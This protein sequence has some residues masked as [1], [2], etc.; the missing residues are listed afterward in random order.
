M[1]F[2][3]GAV[4]GMATRL[5]PAG[6]TPYEAFCLGQAAYIKEGKRDP[7]VPPAE[8]SRQAATAAIS[9]ALVT[10]GQFPM[11]VEAH[12]QR[13]RLWEH[14]FGFGSWHEPINPEE[15]YSPMELL[16]Q[17]YSVASSS[18]SNGPAK[19]YGAPAV[20]TEVSVERTFRIVVGSSQDGEFIDQMSEALQKVEIAL[21]REV[22]SAGYVWIGEDEDYSI[23]IIGDAD[24]PAGIPEGALDRY[25]PGTVCAMGVV[26][27]RKPG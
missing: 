20:K 26:T 24:L 15:I 23:F 5:V 19:S 7:S 27:A 10:L 22:E 9:Q 18:V 17:G 3:D 13:I 2:M 1:G 12:R 8:V 16:T 6:F 11:G 21:K 14:I 25:F 4:N